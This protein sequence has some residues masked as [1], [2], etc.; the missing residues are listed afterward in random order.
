[1]KAVYPCCFADFGSSISL[2]GKEP[3]NPAPGSNQPS[4]E[5]EHLEQPAEG[6]EKYDTPEEKETKQEQN[7][8]VDQSQELPNNSEINGVRLQR[9]TASVQEEN[10][11]EDETQK[12]EDTE[13]V[14]TFFSTMSHRYGN[15]T[16][17]GHITES[18]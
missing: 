9:E 6:D 2:V 5:L 1:M 3:V 18:S 13:Q 16:Q 10:G 8:K 15:T 7:N 12:V 4:P 14:E 17:E 11:E